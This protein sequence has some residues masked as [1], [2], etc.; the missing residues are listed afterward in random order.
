MIQARE[1]FL[2]QVSALASNKMRSDLDVS[3]ATG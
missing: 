3:F 1:S 2:D